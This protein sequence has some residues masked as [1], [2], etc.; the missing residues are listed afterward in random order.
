MIWL[1]PSKGL[2]KSP[3]CIEQHYMWFYVRTA[4]SPLE[5][6]IGTECYCA[7]P[8]EPHLRVTS[9]TGIRSQI[10]LSH[11]HLPGTPDST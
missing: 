6:E 7:P 5:R 2:L 4:C 3:P 9:I 1:R 10:H 8:M 11:W